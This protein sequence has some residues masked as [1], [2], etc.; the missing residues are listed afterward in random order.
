MASGLRV[1]MEARKKYAYGKCTDYFHSR[2]CIGFV[3]AG[4]ISHSGCAA[5][6]SNA[7]P[8]PEYVLSDETAMALTA[9]HT[10]AKDAM[11]SV[12]MNVGSVRTSHRFEV[13]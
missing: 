13:D 2:N 1:L 10:S 11:H 4:D 7:N 3:R 9:L 12:R 8:T 6:L 5:L